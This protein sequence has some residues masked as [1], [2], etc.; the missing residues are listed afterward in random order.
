MPMHQLADI[1]SVSTGR[2]LSRK[3]MGGIYRVLND[4]TGDDLMTHQLPR[5][6]DHCQPGLIS[7]HPFLADVTPP[8]E[9]CPVADLMVWLE[10]MEQQHGTELEVL[11]VAG[12]EHRNPIEELCDMIGSERVFVAPVTGR[13]GL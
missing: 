13:G 4:L 11:P 2:L 8:P 6:A 9:D 12:W 7:Q 10:A 1:L 3:G 5:A